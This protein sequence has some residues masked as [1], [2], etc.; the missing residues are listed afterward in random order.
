ML[1]NENIK[2][3][4]AKGICYSLEKSPYRV[5]VNNFTYFFSSKRYADKFRDNLLENRELFN[6]QWTS[7]MKIPFESNAMA[8][9]QLYQQIE[10]RGF[11]VLIDGEEVHP[12]QIRFV[13]EIKIS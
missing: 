9:I 11:F 10:K 5:N 3:M 13:G 6:S 2:F 4:S 7:R 1:T 12:W 8:D